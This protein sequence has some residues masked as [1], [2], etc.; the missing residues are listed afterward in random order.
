MSTREILTLQFGHYSNYVGAHFWN[1]Q[2]LS[3]D[4]SGTA[5]TDL[6]HDILYREGQ[7]SRNEVTY[8]PRLLIA[9][10]KGALKTLPQSGGLSDDAQETDLQW[11]TVEKIEEP[12]PEKNQ[13]LAAID[14]VQTTVADG[15]KDY[16]LEESVITWT[17]YLY[18]RFHSRTVNVVNEY[19]HGSNKE[20]FDIYPT[21]RGVWKSDYGDLF[22]DNIRK[23][24]E[25]CDSMQGFQINFDCTDGFAGLALGCIEHLSDEY[26]KPILA[27]PIIASHFPDN[28]SNTQEERDISNLRDSI[29]LV[30]ILLS[31]QELSEHATMYVPL[32]TGEKG[33][34]KPGN[35]RT[36]DCLN[37]DPKLYY[38]SSAI[39]ASAIDTL[40]Q[41]YRHKSNIHTMSD[42]CADMTGYGR[43]MT[44]ASL[45]MPIAINESQYL[46]D[47]L[48][49]RIQPIYSCITP[50]CKIANDKLF[51]LITIRGIPES[52]LKA[53]PKEAK[54]QQNLPAY[55]CNSVK[56]MFELYF[57]AN[58]FLSATNLT[59]NEQPL[60][61]K[62]PFPQ[63]FTKN[64]NKYGF[65]KNDNRLED[66]E[67]CAVIAGYHNGTFLA[68]MIEKLHRDVS[69]IRF[70]K[71]HKFKEEGLE[72]SEYTE[73]LDKLAE[74]KDNYEDDFEL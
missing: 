9:D 19:Q 51:Q 62:T 7:T 55:R 21:G 61:L 56:E 2:E 68:N 33:W 30:N 54:A 49:E 13:Y 57:Q 10:L 26:T 25:E 59:V 39:L 46:I 28:N 45:G 1:I 24:V 66:V 15:K 12:P 65:I 40:S 22:S 44:A 3:F 69:R 16:N 43:K 36:F 74:F 63:I 23:Y 14:S 17:D 47:Y 72:A 50:G 6:N 29:R 27:Y 5:T 38:H 31:I 67:S 52:Y 53:P 32:C 73:S 4:Y 42:I 35:A 48:N 34:R 8:T 71:L 20:A 18:P 11:D 60:N 70:A 64:L 41:K 58:N 37:Y